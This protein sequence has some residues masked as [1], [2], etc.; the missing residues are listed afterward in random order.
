MGKDYLNDLEI[1]T[2]FDFPKGTPE[3]SCA[4]WSK[5]GNILVTGH[6]NGFFAIWDLRENRLVLKNNLGSYVEK[7]DISLKNEVLIACHSGDIYLISDL[8][9]TSIELIKKGENNKYTRV[10]NLNWFNSKSFIA[11][12]SY[13]KIFVYSK[14]DNESWELTQLIQHNNSI[15]AS[16]F[17]KDHLVTGDYSGL[18]I[19]WKLINNKFEVIAKIKTSSVIEDIKWKSETSFSALTMTGH[20]LYIEFDE[21]DNSWS[22]VF[23]A[24]VALARGIS[25]DFVNSGRDIIAI[26]G[27]ELLHIGLNSQQVNKNKAKNGVTINCF[28]NDDVRVVTQSSVLKITVHDIRIDSSLIKYKYAKI[29]LFGHTGV[30][31]SSLCDKIIGNDDYDKQSTYGKKIWEWDIDNQGEKRKIVFHDHGGQSSVMYTY[32]PF[33]LDSDILL[34][35]FSKTDRTTFEII[36]DLIPKIKERI[37]EKTKVMLVETK[38]DQHLPDISDDEMQEI[39]TKKNAVYVLKT[40]SEN[41]T[42]IEEMKNKLIGEISWDKARVIIR[43]EESE[44]LFE[45]IKELQKEETYILPKNDVQKLYNSKYGNISKIH[46]NFLLES[47]SNEGEIEYYPEASDYIVFGGE[48]YKE[49]RSN[50]PIYASEKNGIVNIKDVFQNFSGQKAYAKVEEYIKIIDTLFQR[51]KIHIKN[52]DIRYRGCG[53][54]FWN[55]LIHTIE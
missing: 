4:S 20:V 5:D 36:K 19:I 23:D 45:L 33:I 14:S 18:I 9:G 17:H 49:L 16:D 29:S 26:T 44:N 8:S 39:V 41:G 27:D 47:F 42:G 2:I 37:S 46:L 51:F 10:W 25:T 32:I 43:S 28:K 22:I 21:Q 13:G 40:S 1:S 34:L 48:H 54:C 31:K 7:I 52:N 15:F 50:I 53:S 6:K 35:L 24:F 55:F 3:I 30:G 12:S 38:I 11:T